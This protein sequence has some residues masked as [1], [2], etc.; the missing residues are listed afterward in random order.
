M[1]KNQKNNA[2]TDTNNTNIDTNTNPAEPEVLEG[3]TI[4][5]DT[6]SG[7]GPELEPTNVPI[8]PRK[9]RNLRAIEA[10]KAAYSGGTLDKAYNPVYFP[11]AGLLLSGGDVCRLF[12]VSSK[13]RDEHCADAGVKLVSVGPSSLLAY[14]DALVLASHLDSIG[15]SP[16]ASN[17]DEPEW[18]AFIA[19]AKQ[20][21][22]DL[23][24]EDQRAVTIK[25]PLPAM[26]AFLVAAGLLDSLDPVTDL[27]SRTKK[28]SPGPVGVRRAVAA[29]SRDW[30]AKQNQKII[31]KEKAEFDKHSKP[32]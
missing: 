30:Q 7:D 1:A 26:V 20:V 28:S 27:E 2:S 5:V 19:T 4:Q 32:A 9:G 21:Y 23:D 3:P 15:N 13:E 31:A 17:G 10:Y 22:P 16:G 12:G 8:Q 24:S 25:L 6:A 18:S 11:G 29:L 14:A